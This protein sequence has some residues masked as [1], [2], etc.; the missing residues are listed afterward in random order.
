MYNFLQYSTYYYAEKKLIE[1]K[2]FLKQ[3]YEVNKST[4]KHVIG[5]EIDR[6]YKIVQLLITCIYLHYIF[7]AYVLHMQYI[8]YL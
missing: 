3:V 2:I 1:S 8:K 6:R 5:I 7:C 4:G